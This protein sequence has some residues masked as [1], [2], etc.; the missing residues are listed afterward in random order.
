MTT[1]LY[2]SQTAA[3]AGGSL[4]T[5]SQTSLTIHAYLQDST[6]AKSLSLIKQGVQTEVLDAKHAITGFNNSQSPKR[7]M[8]GFFVSPPVKAGFYGPG[9]YRAYYAQ[10]IYD[11]GL[12]TTAKSTSMTFAVY[13]WRPSTGAV[14]R[15]Y[16]TDDTILNNQLG[17]GHPFD[18]ELANDF[19]NTTIEPRGWLAR[20]GDVFIVEAI[21]HLVISS[22]STL[23]NCASFFYGG[24]DV[25]D[26]A[27]FTLVRDTRSAA[28][29]IEFPFDI[30][31]LNGE[32][33]V[34]G[35]PRAIFG[36]VTGT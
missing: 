30:V 32:S 9:K 35:K 34:P 6:T 28:S 18:R 29:F 23:L 7:A 8:V 3:S 27:T 22:V 19:T 11:L 31:W 16:N 2:F 1:R 15:T 25:I 20:D 4:P 33:P 36:G 14:V 13:L 17:T 21:L 5:V 24:N 26:G 12:S 10:A